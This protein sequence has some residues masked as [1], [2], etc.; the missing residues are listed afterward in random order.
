MFVPKGFVKLS[1]GSVTFV[2]QR[3]RELC[4]VYTANCIF[5]FIK[6]IPKITPE[7][8]KY[9]ESCIEKRI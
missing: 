8:L 7:Y 1:D 6:K 5:P 2:L 3:K 9:H 4:A